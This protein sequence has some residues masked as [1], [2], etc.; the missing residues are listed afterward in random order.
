MPAHLS[1]KAVSIA[2][3][4][5][6]QMEP[7]ARKYQKDLVTDLHFL[8]LLLVPSNGLICIW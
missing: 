5:D 8:L 7:V 3:S 4:L 2:S 1:K 6:T